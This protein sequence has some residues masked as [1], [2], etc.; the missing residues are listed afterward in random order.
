MT[1]V[2]II[3]TLAAAAAVA[4]PAK[5][6]AGCKTRRCKARVTGRQCSQR[7]T[8]ACVLHVIYRRRVTGWRR[9]WLLRVPGCESHWN[10]YAYF[11]HSANSAPTN[12]IYTGDI[13]AGLYEFKPSTWATTP[14][15]HRS[16]WSARWQAFAAEWM[17]VQG[18][19]GEWACT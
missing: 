16:I 18:R 5:A 14:Y 19:S 7:N 4:V 12:T 15:A 8:R 2:R 17:T 9:A 1:V 6:E 11:G 13:S 3:T 10:A